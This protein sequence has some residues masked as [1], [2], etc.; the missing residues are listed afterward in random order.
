MCARSRV[1]VP[2]RPHCDRVLPVCER[3]RPRE[4]LR[5]RASSSVHSVVIEEEFFFLGLGIQNSSVIQIWER[6]SRIHRRTK[7]S[8]RQ[9]YLLNA[10]HF[11]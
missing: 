9:I 3:R 7:Y 6:V 10:N 2:L 4:L 8:P 5:F 1:I 11:G